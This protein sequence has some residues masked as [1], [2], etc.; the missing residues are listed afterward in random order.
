MGLI[1]MLERSSVEGN[2]STLQYSF[3]GNSMAEEPG[4]YSP[5]AHGVAKTWIQLSD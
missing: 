4:S 5:S 1:P 3:L 2:G